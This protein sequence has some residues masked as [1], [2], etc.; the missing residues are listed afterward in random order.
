MRASLRRSGALSL[1]AA[2]VAGLA[3]CSGE[4][5]APPPPR[6]QAV[7]AAR[8]DERAVAGFCDQRA[9]AATARPFA[10]PPLAGEAPAA[11]GTW[12]WVNVWA[13]W[14][15]PCVAEMPTVVKWRDDL[16]AKG[17]PIDLLF[18][19][20]D[21]EVPKFE[22]FQRKHPEWKLDARVRDAKAD[23][24]AWFE[25]VGL[26]PDTAI[27]LHFFI[28]PEGRTRCLRAGAIDPGDFPV[29]E[30]VLGG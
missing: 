6:F 29:L 19:S 4:P 8:P 12:R 15:G 23:L 30:A 2:A 3:A 22:A 14:C 28:D 5:A 25:A 26:S 10:L 18:L 21:H 27:P 13:T 11:T 16:A 17:K 7:Q 20:A 1:V 9:D 24:P